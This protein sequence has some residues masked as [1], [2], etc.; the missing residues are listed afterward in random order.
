MFHFIIIFVNSGRDAS[1]SEILFLC[2][3]VIIPAALQETVGEAWIEPGTAAW[4]PDIS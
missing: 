1:Q 3:T 4:Q 2:Y